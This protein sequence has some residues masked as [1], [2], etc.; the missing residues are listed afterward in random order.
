[1]TTNPA[2]NATI[3]I[4]PSRIPYILM[5]RVF[6]VYGRDREAHSRLTAILKSLGIEV[7]D[8][9][10]AIE[11]SGKP[12]PYAKEVL[13]AAMRNVDAVVILMSGDEEAR[14]RPDLCSD[15][16]LVSEGALQP[17]ARP[18]VIFEAGLAFALFPNKTILVQF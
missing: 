4:S 5:S 17:Q 14:L 11:L 12:A 7:L 8:W 6:V 15:Y 9:E 10:G 3:R 1:M 16:E 18:N 13:Q 2:T